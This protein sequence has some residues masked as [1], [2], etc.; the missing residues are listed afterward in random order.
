M[1]AQQ[2]DTNRSQLVWE[3]VRHEMQFVVLGCCADVSN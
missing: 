1:D 3:S 2:L